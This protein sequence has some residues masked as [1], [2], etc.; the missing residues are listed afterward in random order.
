FRDTSVRVRDGSSHEKAPSSARILR[1]TEVPAC[2]GI[3][4]SFRH[5]TLYLHTHRAR[6]PP[7]LQNIFQWVKTAFPPPHRLGQP[8]GGRSTRT[9]R[10]QSAGGV[11]L[12]MDEISNPRPP[13]P[14]FPTEIPM[15]RPVI[16]IDVHRVKAATHGST[17][18]CRRQFMTGPRRPVNRRQR[19]GT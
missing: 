14:A 9:A 12:R 2:C 16:A 10:E 11:R 3:P 13:S 4:C 19:K 5:I 17:G 1:V 7:R 6:T 18:P 8:L 15:C